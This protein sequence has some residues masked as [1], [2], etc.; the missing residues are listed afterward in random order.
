METMETLLY[1][2]LADKMTELIRTGAIAVNER[3]PSVRQLS[4][5]ENVSVSTVLAAYN[6][7]EEQGWVAVRPKSGYYVRRRVR[8]TGRA[9]SP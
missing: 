3:L 8:I 9:Q 5:R 4:K 6:L 2:Q 1:A 7:L